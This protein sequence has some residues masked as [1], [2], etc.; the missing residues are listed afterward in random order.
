MVNP[1]M[2]TTLPTVLGMGVVARTTETLFD[3]RGRRIKGKGKSRPVS[4]SR[5]KSAT[6]IVGVSPSKSG[7]ENYATGYRKALKRQGRPYIGKVKTKRVSGGYAA[8]Y[9]RGR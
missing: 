6:I 4:T 9:L 8:V 7:A 1:L 5:P 3:R 2:T